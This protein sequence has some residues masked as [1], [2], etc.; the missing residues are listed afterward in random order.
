MLRRLL[1]STAGAE[2]P[3]R[4][5]MTKGGATFSER[6]PWMGAASGLNFRALRQLEP[7]IL[8]YLWH[9]HR[10]PAIPLNGS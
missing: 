2:E 7:F 4:V 5:R 10:I 8:S 9:H 1:L 6:S 3:R